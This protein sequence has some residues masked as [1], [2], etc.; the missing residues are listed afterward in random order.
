M[1]SSIFSP[2]DP[3]HAHD[4]ESSVT[5]RSDAVSGVSGGGAGASG[6]RL[7]RPVAAPTAFTPGNQV[8]LILCGLIASGKVYH[9]DPR[10]SSRI[11]SVTDGAAEQFRGAF[12]KTLPGIQAMQSRR[13]G[14]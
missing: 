11:K 8:V 5:F 7:E 1:A 2:T 13:S 3:A 12:A 6:G 4:E 10:Q 14:G 9:I